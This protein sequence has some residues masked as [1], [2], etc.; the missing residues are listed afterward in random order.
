M[1]DVQCQWN[2]SSICLKLIKTVG[3]I[4]TINTRLQMVCSFIGTLCK[5]HNLHYAKL[6]AALFEVTGRRLI[7]MAGQL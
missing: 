2:V 4:P 6:E 5:I 3:G 1:K 7:A